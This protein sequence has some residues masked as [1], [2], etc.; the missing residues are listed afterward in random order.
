MEFACLLRDRPFNLH[1][2]HKN[3]TF[4]R[5]STNDMVIRWGV[6]LGE[7]CFNVFKY[8][9]GEDN[10]IADAMS[11]L[12]Q[13]SLRPSQAGPPNHLPDNL[14]AAVIGEFRIPGT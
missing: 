6:A 7:F 11:C 4:I 9:K 5:D 1:T 12:C 13:R 10:S 8:V 14:V 3:L 2:D